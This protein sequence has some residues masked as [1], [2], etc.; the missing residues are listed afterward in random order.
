VEVI[1]Q[2]EKT[3]TRFTFLNRRKKVTSKEDEEIISLEIENLKDIT[4]TNFF[5]FQIL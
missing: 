1:K 4:T 3:V 2:L 5:C